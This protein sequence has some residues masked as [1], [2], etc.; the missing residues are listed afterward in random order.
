MRASAQARPSG[1]AICKP[2]A[3]SAPGGGSLMVAAVGCIDLLL[4]YGVYILDHRSKHIILVELCF[5]VANILADL[6]Q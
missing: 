2:S 5:F 6:E 3:P 1:H 4:F